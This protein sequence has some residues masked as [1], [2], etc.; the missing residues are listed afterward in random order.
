[1]ETRQLAGDRPPEGDELGG[2]R[3]AALV[4]GGLGGKAR[5]EVR[6]APARDR[7][8]TALARDPKQ[9]LRHHQADE[10]VVADEPGSSASALGLRRR[11]K[12][13]A[14]SAIDCDQEGV[15][16]GVTHCGLLVDI[17]LAT[18][19]FDTLVSAPY[20]VITAWA[21]NYRSRI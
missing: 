2:K 17:A 18:P 4:V 20:P 19:T 3:P 12:E 9:H 10:L 1:V 6:Q 15:E 5:E 16:V 8:E 7:Q 11:R 21:V 13:R 14:G